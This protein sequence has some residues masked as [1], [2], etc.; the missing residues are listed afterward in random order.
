MLQKSDLKSAWS[1][2]GSKRMFTQGAEIRSA[3]STIMDF[4]NLNLSL[5]QVTFTE[6]NIYAKLTQNESFH[7]I[8]SN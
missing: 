3:D 2:Q 4:W 7:I 5:I 1:D 8:E 6:K